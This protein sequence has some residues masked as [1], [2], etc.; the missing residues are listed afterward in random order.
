LVKARG[1]YSGTGFVATYSVEATA[2]GGELSS[3]RGR[4]AS[5][6][7]P[8]NYPT[9]A[10]CVWTVGGSPGNR[11]QLSFI[12][13]DVEESDNCHS[14]YV[15]VHAGSAEGPLLGHYCGATVP[16]NHTAAEKLWI[17]FNSDS[18]GSASGFV[19]EYSLRTVNNLL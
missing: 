2:C 6:S 8:A 3:A 1:A 10:Q 7:F 16:V 11:V 13:F 17:K 5:P 4:F 14:D 18:S 15:E 9:G 12:S 19:A